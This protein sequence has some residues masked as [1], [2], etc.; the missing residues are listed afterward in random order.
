MTM[1]AR[2][3]KIKGDILAYKYYPHK[4]CDPFIGEDVIEMWNM[5]GNE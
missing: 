5:G 1:K 2:K 4:A 3:A